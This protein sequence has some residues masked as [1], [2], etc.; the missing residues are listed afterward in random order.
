MVNVYN[1]YPATSSLAWVAV[2]ELPTVE[3]EHHLALFWTP[4]IFQQKFKRVVN[5]NSPPCSVVDFQTASP[6]FPTI[7]SETGNKERN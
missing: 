7:C 2:F 6:I 1:S 4:L 5:F 3:V